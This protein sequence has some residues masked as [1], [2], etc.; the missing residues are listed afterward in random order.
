MR[1]ASFIIFILVGTMVL[2]FVSPT[3]QAAGEQDDVIVCC[4]ASTVELYLL[5]SDSNKQL[6]PF[7]AELSA[8]SQAISM[9]NSI[10]SQET[11]GKWTLSNSWGGEVPSS[12]W[13]FSMGYEVSGAAGAQINATVSIAIGSKSYSAQTDPSGSILGQGKGSLDFS[14][15]VDE[16]FTLAESSTVVLELKVQTLLFS[17]PEGTDAELIFLWGGENDPSS[18]VGTLPLLDIMMPEPEI[19][20]SDVYLAVKLDSPWGLSTL[21]LAESISLS[22]NGAEVTGDP[23]ET[24]SGDTVRV[25]WTW[26]KAI[27]GIESIDVAVS[28][29]FQPD[30]PELQGSTTFEIETFDTNS[31]TGTYYPPDEPLR[32]NGDG[33]SL[34]VDIQMDLS[35]D[36]D[37]LLLRKVTTLTIGDEMAFWMRWGMD[38]IGDENPA[39]SSTLRAFS[40]GSVSEEDRVSRSIEETEIGEFER[41]M[42]SLG[43]MYLSGGLGIQAE[44][45]L[46]VFREFSS[47]K[48]DL[49]L[50]GETAVVNHPVTLRFSTTE[51]VAE[52]TQVDLINQFIIV[53]PAPLWSSFSLSLTAKTSS[54]T[55]LSNNV[56]RESTQFQLSIL[57]MPW[58][59]EITLEGEGISQ[60]EAFRL[61]SV[62]TS[63][64]SFTPMPLTLLSVFG[65]LGAFMVGMRITRQRKRTVMYTELV[66]VP[67]VGLVLVL[68]YPAIFV[69]GAVIASTL[70]WWV[71]AIASPRLS[72][73]NRRQSQNA[74]PTIPCPA[75]QVSNPVTSTERPHRFA[76]AGCQR[77]IR[78]EA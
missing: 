41:Q 48:V 62:P 60:D 34:V 31:G 68:G 52:G 35:K 59:D 42:V 45:L 4:D 17:F 76:C 56:L 12:T 1:T 47:L 11:V 22:V 29:K 55:S 70:I 9:K 36:G 28:L 21:A 10:S 20:G 24:A 27:G 8:E 14:I 74:Y 73:R 71:T 54:F 30:Q 58:G 78:L 51:V 16:T 40:E 44:D 37:T 33:S 66:L 67:V 23:I 3:V 63:A 39:L 57:R 61:N 49:D 69:G 75:C 18:I 26:T 2:P 64:V 19:E 53:Q 13:S 5:G 77:I 72:P 46:G 15:N 50:N 6:T 25:T 7:F 32:T 43:P 65:L 38:H